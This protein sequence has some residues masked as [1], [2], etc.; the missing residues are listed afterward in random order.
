MFGNPTEMVKSLLM[1]NNPLMMRA[2]DMA[3]GKSPQELQTVA[4]NLARERGISP[5]QLSSLMQNPMGFLM[6]SG[7]KL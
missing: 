2:W 6:Q 3:Q 5:E 7:I 1:Q 4:Q